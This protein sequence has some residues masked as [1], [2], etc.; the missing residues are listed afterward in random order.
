[1]YV[2]ISPQAQNFSPRHLRNYDGLS[3]PAY[4]LGGSDV[5]YSLPPP[6][7]LKVGKIGHIFVACIKLEIGQRMEFVW[8][9]SHL[10]L[11]SKF[12]GG[13]C[14]RSAAFDVKVWRID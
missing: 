9:W 14:R 1:M 2:N 11:D 3:G 10:S 7:V 13:T 4:T 6:K 8:Y 5:K 12:N